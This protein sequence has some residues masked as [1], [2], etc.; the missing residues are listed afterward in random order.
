MEYVAQ[1]LSP[2]RCEQIDG[3]TKSEPNGRFGLSRAAAVR[4][5][6]VEDFEPFLQFIS[7]TLGKRRDLQVIGEVSDGLEAVQEAVELKPDLIIMDI[8]LPSLNGIEAARQIRKLLPE[9]KIIFLSGEYS[10]DV[11]QEAL[12]LGA[13]GYVIK[14][15]AGTDLLAAVDAVI[16]GKQFVSRT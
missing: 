7:S 5:L 14:T 15:S 16:L 2:S 8:G 6:V 3:P 11:V 12:S 9:S 10:A 13:W 4:V 1:V